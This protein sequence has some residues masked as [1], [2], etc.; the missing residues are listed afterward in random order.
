M[1]MRRKEKDE[2]IGGNGSRQER[3]AKRRKTGEEER[4]GRL[5]RRQEEEDWRG[6]RLE[7]RKEDEA[8]RGGNG[9]KE[10]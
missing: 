1:R 9:R 8:Q 2:K 3:G 6:G 4:G 5:E 10:K 7:K